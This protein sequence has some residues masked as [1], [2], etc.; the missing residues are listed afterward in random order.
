[1][2]HPPEPFTFETAKEILGKGKCPCRIANDFDRPYHFEIVHCDRH[3]I[4][5]DIVNGCAGLNPAAYRECVE[6]L[7][8]YLQ[9]YDSP[10]RSA[11]VKA[12]LER[13]GIPAMRRAVAHAQGTG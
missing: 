1:M 13:E 4:G 12:W 5:Y 11:E 3:R 6:A 7:T 10:E 2:S 9:H 8:G